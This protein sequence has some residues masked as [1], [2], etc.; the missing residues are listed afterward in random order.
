MKRARK[1][2]EEMKAL[3]M[4]D[5]EEQEEESD[6]NAS[7]LPDEEFDEEDMSPDENYE[8]NDFVSKR[9]LLEAAGSEEE[10]EEGSEAG[11]RHPIE[12]STLELNASPQVLDEGYS[13]DH[14]D[15]L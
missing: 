4:V 6:E 12:G 13:E 8:L 5:E 14:I 15:K 7:L 3:D 2:K 1:R 10:E 9:L 11:E